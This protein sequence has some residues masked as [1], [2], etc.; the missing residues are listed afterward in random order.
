MLIERNSSGLLFSVSAALD[1]S[2]T[3]DSYYCIA[4]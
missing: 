4:Q 2:R 1:E 3:V